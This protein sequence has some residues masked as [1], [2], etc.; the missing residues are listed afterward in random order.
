MVE[1]FEIKRDDAER[2][3]KLS[4]VGNGNWDMLDGWTV[5]IPKVR[6]QTLSSLQRKVGLEM[7]PLG[8]HGSPHVLVQK[9]LAGLSAGYFRNSWL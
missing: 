9:V 3:S 6:P 7:E 5:A 4:K 1:Y 2:P 8:S